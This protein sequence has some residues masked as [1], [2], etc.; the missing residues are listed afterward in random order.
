MRHPDHL[1]PLG[2]DIF[3]GVPQ[4]RPGPL[5]PRIL[6]GFCA[7][8]CSQWWYPSRQRPIKQQITMDS[9]LSFEMIY[10]QT[11]RDKLSEFSAVSIFALE[12]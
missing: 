6:I 1:Y 11:A 4:G 10:K 2:K 12:G 7:S 8:G 3:R 9:S 5:I